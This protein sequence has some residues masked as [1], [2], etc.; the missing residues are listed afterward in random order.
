MVLIGLSTS[1]VSY[2]ELLNFNEGTAFPDT[3]VASLTIPDLEIQPDDILSIRVKA[4]NEEAAAPFNLMREDNNF[5]FRAD[6]AGSR[7]IGYLV[8]KKG[9]IDF[10][11]IGELHLAG[12]T[13]NE[14]KVVIR[15][16]LETYLKNPTVI[17]RFLN[18]R[19]T[20]LGEV[21]RPGIYTMSNERVTILDVIGQAGDITSY[22]NRTNV[23]LIREY[24]G[25]RKYARLN[26]QDRDVFQSPN[27]YLLQND[28]IYV[29]PLSEKTAQVRDQSQRIL[30]WISVVT[31]LT[32]LALTLTRL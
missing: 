11:V 31:T 9:N 27:F 4:L 10:P 25:E 13:T 6:D 18:F 2:Q 22:G 29:E 26:L 12:M 32:T 17:V 8:D 16:K 30:P 19:V 3:A 20:V 23:L 5:N 28:V 14:A 15:D 21:A 7:L 1:C 24:N